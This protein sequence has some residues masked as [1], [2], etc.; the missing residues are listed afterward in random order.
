MLI[1]IYSIQFYA[2]RAVANS[3][4]S[5]PISERTALWFC[6][7][8]P[9]SVVGSSRCSFSAGWSTRFFVKYNTKVLQAQCNLLD[10]L[11]YSITIYIFPILTAKSICLHFSPTVIAFIAG[12][13]DV[14]V[15]IVFRRL[16]WETRTG[17]KNT[18]ATFQTAEKSTE[19]HL[20]W[21]YNINRR[22]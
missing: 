12:V 3:S 21:R 7:Q 1:F 4:P 17:K 16:T 22:V 14:A 20:I 10:Y 6:T 9:S 19:K 13:Q 18:F 8:V 15:R 11:E 2:T 5:K